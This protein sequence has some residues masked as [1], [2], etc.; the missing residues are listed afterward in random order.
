[1]STD[2]VPVGGAMVPATSTAVVPT[3][4]PLPGTTFQR[5][6]VATAKQSAAPVHAQ[7][8]QE[9]TADFTKGLTSEGVP[10]EHIAKALAWYAKWSARESALEKQLDTQD[11]AD[12]NA[13]LRQKWGTSFVANKRAA[14]AAFGALPPIMQAALET[15]TMS[16]GRLVLHTEAA[17]ELLLDST[18]E[19]APSYV[20]L[21]S[22]TVGGTEQTELA[23]LRK[24]MGDKTGPYW[25]GRDAARNQARYKELIEKGV[26]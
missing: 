21:A 23:T 4:G 5:K 19:R 8:E 18:R 15:G 3:A 11:L 9:V 14:R 10:Q 16:D 7:S 20:A 2:I 25:K 13:A 26:R 17:W 1:M 22:T 12:C 24:M 6:T